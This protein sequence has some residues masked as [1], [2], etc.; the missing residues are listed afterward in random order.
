MQL[1]WQV[2]KNLEH[3]FITLADVVLI[4]DKQQDVYSMKIA[5]L[6][7]RTVV[8]IEAIA[9]EL[10]LANG[11]DSTLADE[12]MYYDTVCIAHLDD[13][14]KICRKK[15][16]VVSP[17]LYFE[18]EENKILTP[19]AK[20]RKRGKSSAIWNRAYQ[21]VKHNRV[22][23]IAKG[24]IKHLLRA[25]A[26][27]YVLNL[28]YKDDSIEKLTEL[29]AKQTNS[30]F[31]SELFAVNI[32]HCFELNQDGSYV[33]KDNYDECAYIVDYENNS[34]SRALKA[35]R[36]VNEAIS[37][38]SV[39]DIMEQV[40]EKLAK[41]ETPTQ[42]WIDCKKSET[43]SNAVHSIDYKLSRELSAGIAGMRYNIVLNKQQH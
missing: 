40:N 7:I 10:Y 11:G 32:H 39:D 27:L 3:E 21:A 24:N 36:N 26:A 19:L 4:N 25:L 38:K 22:K 17:N 34:K 1:Y 16:V 8:E 18:N 41:G 37:K 42:E 28:Y 31:G 43:F 30:S 15:I 12:E 2:Y 13:I 35:L 6:L 9:K 14:W 33:K 29:D 23:D 5:D 20:A